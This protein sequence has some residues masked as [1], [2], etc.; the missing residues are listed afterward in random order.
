MG[1]LLALPS[2]SPAHN[3]SVE[4]IPSVVRQET[5]FLQLELKLHYSPPEI[6]NADLLFGPEDVVYVAPT[7]DDIRQ[8]LKFYH[9]RKEGLQYVKDAFDCD[10]FSREFKHWADVWSIRHYLGSRVG[11]AVGM[12]YVHIAGDI[13]DIFPL[14]DHD[15][16]KGYH[17]LNVIVR[18]DGQCLFFEPQTGIL[19]PVESMIYEGSL[20]VIRVNL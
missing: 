15:L 3:D 4:D 14:S 2:L 17:V 20:E 8:L 1:L 9:R 5:L 11:V 12:V 10:N 13:T 19:V 6:E 7:A 16:V 18:N